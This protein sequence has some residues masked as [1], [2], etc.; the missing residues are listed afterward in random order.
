MARPKVE[1]HKTAGLILDSAERHF[2]QKGFKGTSINDVADDAKINKSLI[3][4]HFKDKENLWKAVKERILNEASQNQLE[5]LDFKHPTLKQFLDVFI[6]F[7]FHV[8]AH[9]PKLIRLMEWQR[10]EPDNEAIMFVNS[11]AFVGLDTHIHALQKSGQIRSDLKPDVIF[12][13]V[14][15]M[16]SNGFMDK[17]KFLETEKGRKDYQKFITES[18]M[19]ILSPK[20]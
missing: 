17:V 12:Y 1:N 10:L 15:S 14:L 5:D 19:T 7:R 13:V 18:L 8:Y 16:A 3:Y 2:L 6:P 9:Y 4:H 20:P 11:K